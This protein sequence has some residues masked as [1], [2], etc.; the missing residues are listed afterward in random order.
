MK[1]KLLTVL[2]AVGMATTAYGQC[3][4]NSAPSNNCNYF[5]TQITAFTLNNVA[6]NH[7]ACGSGGYTFMPTP[8]RQLTIGQTY[9]WS[10]TTGS[11]YYSV[12]FAMWIDLDNDGFYAASEMLATSPPNSTH[13]GT[14]FIPYT[15]VA[16]TNR[17]MRIRSGWY[18]SI[19]GNQ[20]CTNWLGGY[21]ETEDYLVDLIPPPPCAGSPASTS[22]VVTPSAGVCSGAT[23]LLGLSTTYTNG[24][25]TYQWG[26]S[27]QSNVGP[28][29]AISGA[30]NAV[31][32]TPP[33]TSNAW[34]QATVTCANSSQFV[35]ATS[36]YVLVQGTTISQVPY[37]ADFE[38]IT[39]P[40][41][42]PNCSWA[43]T[44]PTTI[45]RSYTTTMTQQ[46]SA[47]SGSKF[48]SFYYSPSGSNYVFTNGIQLYSGV[49]YSA[50][51]WYK[52]NNYGDLNWTDMSI[53]L[54][55]SQTST[56]LV[57]IA[58]TNGPAASI[59]YKALTNTFTVANSGIYYVAVKAT[60]NGGCCAQHLNWDDLS[61]TA[62]C[63]LNTPTVSLSPN[64]TSVCAGSSVN[65]LAS[66]ATNYT[67]STG[68]TGNVIYVTPGGSTTYTVLGT[69]T[70]T[71]CSSSVS[72]YIQVLP[73][74]NVLL[75]S[76]KNN[77]CPGQPANL[78]AMGA[79][80]Y[81]WSVQNA[82]TPT[83]MVKP[84][85]TQSYTVYGSNADGCM[86]SAV[87]NIGVYPTPTVTVIQE[88]TE[89]CNGESSILQATGAANYQW[90]SNTLFISGSPISISPNVSTTYTVIGTDL[91]GC[92]NSTTLIQSVVECVGLNGI[93]TTMAG[94]KVYPNPSSGMFTVEVPS[95]GS[96]LIEVTDLTGRVILSNK[97]SDQ[98]VNVNINSLSNGIYYVKIQTEQGSEVIKVVKQ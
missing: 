61:I 41:S 31:Y 62:P 40:N 39:K 67:W 97:S 37:T 80:S 98:F 2:A 51:L 96:R 17:P 30:T 48:G 46:R 10:S 33:V 47:R 19:T 91:N 64:S 77:V 63:S 65:I 90:L 87:H 59:G 81:T 42:W 84:T 20:A 44:N 92:T 23:A 69:N 28:F 85:S 43:A 78:T 49:T 16:G 21:G 72:Q 5:S 29:T 70:I 54:G 83:L 56:G 76:D 22:V 94:V 11:G 13:S 53:M 14:I 1:T 36:G 45:S 9:N 58:S 6:S 4:V 7:P 25:I 50:D 55:Q 71:G 15:S 95:T 82:L 8:V 34:Y 12:G 74:P 66:G 24:G 75:Y 60:N 35:L 68:E 86:S 93:T 27:T 73:T 32:N 57:P 3:S 26:S 18:S 52:T 38:N 89:I 79:T 88:R